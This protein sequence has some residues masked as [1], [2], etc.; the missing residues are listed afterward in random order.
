MMENNLI[1]AFNEMNN[2]SYSS[3]E[4]IQEMYSKAEIFQSWLEY[5]VIYGYTAK[6]LHVLETL[7]NKE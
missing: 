1:N 3:V 4:E 7:E 5:E 2:T 6:I